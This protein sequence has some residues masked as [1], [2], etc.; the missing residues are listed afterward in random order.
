MRAYPATLTPD[1]DGGF[2][3]TFRDLPDAITEGD[4]RDEALLRA[5][6]CRPLRPHSTG[7]LLR[8]HGPRYADRTSRSRGSDRS[9][10]SAVVPGAIT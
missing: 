10:C 3:V 8:S 2:T 5:E 1:P 7:E 9:E 4:N 6:W